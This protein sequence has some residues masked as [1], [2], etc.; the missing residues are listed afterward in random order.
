MFCRYNSNVKEKAKI[1]DKNTFKIAKIFINQLETP[2]GL[3]VKTPVFSWQFQSD[4]PNMKQK[5]VIILL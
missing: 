2:L 4:A 1:M 3:D 5:K